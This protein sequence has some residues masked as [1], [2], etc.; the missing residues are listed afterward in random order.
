MNAKQVIV[1]RKDLGMRKGKMA[2]QGAHA[3]MKVILDA[4]GKWHEDRLEISG[5]SNAVQDWLKHKFTK[6]VVSVKSLEELEVI[7]QK[8]I[9]AKLPCAMIIDSG[10]TEFNGV[11][12]KTCLAIGPADAMEVDKITGDLPLL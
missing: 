6:V 11:E 5:M 9:E 1:I 12:T 10:T 2:S 7:Y 4:F 3:S 8:A